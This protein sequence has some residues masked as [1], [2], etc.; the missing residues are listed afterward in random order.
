MPSAFTTRFQAGALDAIYAQY[1][2]PG[3]LY[4]DKSVQNVPCTPRLNRG[5]NMQISGGKSSM[6]QG[7][8]QPGQVFVRQGEIARPVIGGRFTIDD[9]V[10]SIELSPLLRNGQFECSCVRVNPERRGERRA[11]NG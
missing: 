5:K 9:E 2:I 8:I 6:T 4:G 11:T 1:G 3:S 7:E 10:W